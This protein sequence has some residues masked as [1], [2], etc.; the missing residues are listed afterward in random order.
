MNR[1]KIA[2]RSKKLLLPQTD[3]HIKRAKIQINIGTHGYFYEFV[4][5]VI[6]NK[7]NRLFFVFISYLTYRTCDKRILFIPLH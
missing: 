1:V 6:Y 4:K 3:A 5:H 7:L 2:R